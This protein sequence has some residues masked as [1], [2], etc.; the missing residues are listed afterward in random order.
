METLKNTLLLLEKFNALIR[1]YIKVDK[2]GVSGEKK[3]N[4]NFGDSISLDVIDIL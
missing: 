1:Y 4:F 2:D 3:I